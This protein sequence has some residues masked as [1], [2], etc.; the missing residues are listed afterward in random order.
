MS[1]FRQSLVWLY[2]V[3]SLAVLL[4]QCGLMS[5]LPLVSALIGIVLQAVSCLGLWHYARQTPRW[6]A[7]RWRNV[8]FVQLIGLALMTMVLLPHSVRWT[9]L[10]LLL[11]LPMLLMLWRYSDE[12]QA[13]WFSPLQ[14]QQGALLQALLARYGELSYQ[15]HSGP[16][17]AKVSLSQTASGYQVAVLRQQGK[18][19]EQFSQGY[20]SAAAMAAYLEAYV[21]MQVTDLLAAYPLDEDSAAVTG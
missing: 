17:Q 9:L 14:H 3:L 11:Q 20:R 2:L 15:H 8:V 21:L 6:T 5:Q 19:T 13:Y 7:Y 10:V 12:E 16:V 18:Q 1:R 4:V